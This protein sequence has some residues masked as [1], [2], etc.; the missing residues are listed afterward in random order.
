LNKGGKGPT[1][2]YYK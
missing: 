1:A 2:M